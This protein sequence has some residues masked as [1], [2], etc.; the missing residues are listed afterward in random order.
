MLRRYSTLILA[1]DK[2]FNS[3][4]N[5]LIIYSLETAGCILSYELKIADCMEHLFIN[6]INVCFKKARDYVKYFSI[7]GKFDVV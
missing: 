2:L 7:K 5:F 1:P 3:M 4:Y 6:L